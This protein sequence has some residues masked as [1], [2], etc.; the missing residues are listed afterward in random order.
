MKYASPTER[1]EVNSRAIWATG[2]SDTLGPCW[3]WIGPYNN[4]GRPVIAV[5][6]KGKPTKITISRFI[7]QFVHKLRW[8][9]RT[10][11]EHTCHRGDWCANPDHVF[12]S[13]QKRNVRSCVAAGR[14]VSGFDKARYRREGVIAPKVLTA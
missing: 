9:K 4:A 10:V 13:T 14:H 2:C 1:L 5:R 11:G 3:D 6:I 8:T 12:R 7:V